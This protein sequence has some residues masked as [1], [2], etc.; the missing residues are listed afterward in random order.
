MEVNKDFPAIP[1]PRGHETILLVED[2]TA[3]LHMTSQ[4]LESL[5]YTVL[6][7]DTPS[8]AIRLANEFSGIIDLLITDV[9]MPEMTGRDLANNLQSV[10]P[11]LKQLFMSGY[12]SNVIVHHGVLEDGVYFIQK[13]FSM[14]GLAAKLR[15]V[16]GPE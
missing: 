5:G 2:E 4:M 13:P 12:T 11:H 14:Q 8:E 7:S 3:I 9:V 10:Y 15:E 6:A 1:L 16:L